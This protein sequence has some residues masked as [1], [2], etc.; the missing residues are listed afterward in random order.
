M[1]NTGKKD[2]FFF[3][4]YLPAQPFNNFKAFI[5]LHK[6]IFLSYEFFN[7]EIKALKD[8]AL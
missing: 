1:Y 7:E 3:F 6:N 2:N 5:H 8:S 4:H